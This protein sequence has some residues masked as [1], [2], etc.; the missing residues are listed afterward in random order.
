MKSRLA[1]TVALV[2]LPLLAWSSGSSG[3]GGEETTSGSSGRAS[4]SGGSSG[5]GSSGAAPTAGD[6][7]VKDFGDSAG[8]KM[9]VHVPASVKADAPVVVALHGCTQTA[10]D[11]AKAGWNELA[12]VRGFYVVYPEQQIANNFSRCF[13]WFDGAHTARGTGEPAAIAA[14]VEYARKTFGA[15]RAY[16]TGLS[17]GGA[18]TAVMLATY[19]DLF[20][21]GAVMSGLPYHCATSQTDA[22]TCMNPGKSKTAQAWGDL[23]RAAAS[24]TAPRLQVWHGDAD[25]TVRPMNLGELAKQ[26]ANAGGISEASPK[27]DKTGRATHRVYAD[28][29]GTARVET[30]EV[31][32]MAHG[33]PVD[34]KG[35][36]GKAGAYVLDVGLCSSKYAADFFGL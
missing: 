21:A 23:V 5:G 25:Y 10:A 11:Y 2:A 22:Y 20:D 30:F 9:F 16:V 1:V 24:G 35:G 8:L 34:P 27:T 19:P 6:M 15:G 7:E 31:S 4:S 32:G 18:M 28:A 14:M 29:S 26:F 13:R 12:D 36:C 17:A 3:G 33:V